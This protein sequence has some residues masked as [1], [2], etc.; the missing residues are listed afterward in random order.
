MKLKNSI[1][2]LSFMV[3][4]IKYLLITDIHGYV[5][6]LVKVLRS[7]KD[8]DAILLAGDI[9]GYDGRYDHVLKVLSEEARL[10][11]SIVMVIGNMDNPKLLNIISENYP[12]IKCLH[13]NLTTVGN[14]MIAGLSGGLYSPFNTPFELGE[15]DFST[16]IKNIVNELRGASTSK[17]FILLTHTPPYKT[18]VDVVYRGEHVGSRAIRKFIEE[19]APLAVVSGHIHEA[20]GIDR[21]GNSIIVNPGPLFKGFYGFMSVNDNNIDVMLLKLKN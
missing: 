6:P 20:R 9:S 12:E 10:G 14:I 17:R 2:L 18:K 3:I 7:E 21:I 13:G 4:P 11:I 16:L 5:K 8:Y 19:L 1:I 15:D